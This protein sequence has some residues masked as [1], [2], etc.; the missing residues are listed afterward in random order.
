MNLGSSD[1]DYWLT[2]GASGY[3]IDGPLCDIC[4]PDWDDDGIP[5]A[6]PSD[7]D[8]RN[9][10]IRG[11]YSLAYTDLNGNSK[12]FSVDPAVELCDSLDN[13]CNGVK[14]D[15]E[16]VDMV[17]IIDPSGTMKSQI[18]KVA[19]AVEKFAGDWDCSQHRFAIVATGMPYGTFNDIDRNRVYMPF[20]SAQNLT[21]R[22]N[23]LAAETVA[24]SS[25]LEW[26]WHETTMD[27][28]QTILRDEDN[29]YGLAW[30]PEVSRKII[31]TFSDTW[32]QSVAC[33]DGCVENGSGACPDASFTR[34]GSNC[35]RFDQ[36]TCTSDSYSGPACYLK[37]NYQAANYNWSGSNLSNYSVPESLHN[38]LTQDR[39][40]GNC[41]LGFG[42]E[43]LEVW[44]YINGGS[45]GQ[46]AQWDYIMGGSN[47]TRNIGPKDKED[48]DAEVT[49]LYND[50]KGTVFAGVCAPPVGET[51][52]E[53][54]KPLPLPEK[55][56]PPPPQITSLLPLT[57]QVNFQVFISGFML[58]NATS[59]KFNGTPAV[60]QANS[61][62]SITVLVPEGAT[63]GK[64]AVVVDGK[65]L[66]SPQS[67]DVTTPPPYCGDRQCNGDEFCPTREQYEDIQSSGSSFG[68]P[69]TVNPYPNAC[70][71]DCCEGGNPY[72]GYVPEP[73]CGNANNSGG[74]GICQT[75]PGG[76][77]ADTPDYPGYCEYYPSASIS[78]D[79]DIL[80]RVNSM[81]QVCYECD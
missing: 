1:N 61:S 69:G 4:D 42:C 55:M 76:I 77:W 67:F 19:K 28:L 57:G 53:Y 5:N 59:V 27:T 15:T 43:S 39:G 62:N 6:S 71:Q 74:D 11:P 21:T 41:K 65:T 25:G 30:R 68:N 20:S 40:K 78:S 80:N 10:S 32:A 34:P 35:V 72:P 2:H 73:S 58:S 66:T 29:L 23:E 7:C 46:V 31:V 48:D 3:G 8:K 24:S 49:R 45:S 22:M 52:E 70:G 14:D 50:L 56:P 12:T 16:P 33:G 38:T 81:C 79:V 26:A 63:D 18:E 60:I 13:N 75:K 47:Y 44:A 54:C 51:P 17:F 64:I 36:P 9:P 37:V